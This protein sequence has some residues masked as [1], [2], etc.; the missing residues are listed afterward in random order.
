MVPNSICDNC[1]KSFHKKPCQK[2]TSKNNFCS[3]KCYSL[4]RIK[5]NTVECLVCNRKFHRIKKEQRFCSYKCSASRPRHLRVRN[6]IGPGDKRSLYDRFYSIGWD[7]KCMVSGCDYDI[8]LDIHRL[9][10]GKDGGKYTLE[11]S[12]IIC[13][14]HH[15]EIHR[16]ISSVYDSSIMILFIK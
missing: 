5:K 4:W 2:N 12:F 10:P 16:G 1:E 14:N 3:R 8:T 11:N 9:I 15:A 13:P 7:G 6:R